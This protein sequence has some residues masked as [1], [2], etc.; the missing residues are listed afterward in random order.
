MAQSAAIGITV[1][2]ML[3]S[4]EAISHVLA[5]DQPLKVEAQLIWG[6]NDSKSPDPKHKPVSEEVK[7]KLK[8]L[9][10]KWSNYFEVNRRVIEIGANS[11]KRETL[12]DKCVVSIKNAGNSKVEVCLFGKGEQVVKQSQDLPVGETL[13]LGGNAPNSTAWLVLLKRMQ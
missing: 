11:A 13:V 8:E 5:A 9:P 12:S 4:L 3:M 2:F 6:T 10:L 7:K 1:A